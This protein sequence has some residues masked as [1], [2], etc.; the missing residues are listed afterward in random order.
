MSEKTLAEYWNDI[1]IGNKNAVTYEYL[2][3]KWCTSD[4]EVR[5]ILH[6]LSCCDNGD[7]YVLIR[8]SASKGFY[9]TDEKN[10]LEA[11]KQECLNKGKSIF[12]PV[13]KINRLLKGNDTQLS[14]I[15]NLRQRRTELEMK[16]QDVCKRMWIVD[17]AFN[18]TLLSKMENGICLPTAQQLEELAEIYTCKPS[19]LIVAEFL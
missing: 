2:C 14:F 15:N 13:R 19:D 6:D 18:V 10:A 9:K 1:P 11:Y 8:S 12:A 4:R 5:K 16:Q 7:D 3:E 17:P